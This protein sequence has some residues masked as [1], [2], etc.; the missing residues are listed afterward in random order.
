MAVSTIPTLRP[1]RLAELLDQAFRLYRRNFLVFISIVAVV[2]IPLT[3]LS[4]A[5]SYYTL[6]SLNWAEV[7]S[8]LD[9]TTGFPRG[10]GPS[11]FASLGALAVVSIIQLVLV[12][13]FATAALV[14]AIGDSYLGQP[15]NLAGAYATVGH[16]WARLLGAI[17]LSL[18]LGIGL[19][20]WLLVPCI[21]WFTGP[22]ILAFFGLVVF[23]LLVP[24]V[25]MEN[26][27]PRRAIR[28]AWDLAR[29]RFW[30]LVGFALV[31]YL[32]GQLIVVGPSL[33]ISGVLNALL[34]QSSS[35][36]LMRQAG[37][38]SVINSLV[39]LFASLVYMPLELTAITLVYFD[40]RMRTEGLDLA[41]QAAIPDGQTADST[42]VARMPA[43]L[44]NQRLVTGREVGY[45][46]L[47]SLV[48]VGIYA[49]FTLLLVLLG[50]TLG[51]GG[52]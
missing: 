34:L 23:Q 32:L 10:M 46:F 33:L 36:D 24:V 19:A 48:P 8:S 40:L 11:Y 3:L 47:L 12:E 20:V 37:I 14:R 39:T 7:L 9:P 30:W 18:L 50:L 41:L 26:A 35:S 25:I 38:S 51:R 2:Q 1:L 15:T 28:R 5:L 44:L 52:V 29:R 43:S 49:C 45:F 42:V 22:G 16:S 21:G 31:L 13:G 27:G 17:L 6:G 4:L